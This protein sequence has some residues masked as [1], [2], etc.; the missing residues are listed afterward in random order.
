VKKQNQSGVGHFLR[1]KG[2]V[3]ALMIIAGIALAG[4][5]F[6]EN[7]SAAEMANDGI[8]AIGIVTHKTQSQAKSGSGST[9]HY[10]LSYSLAIPDDPYVRGTQDVGKTLYDSVS[11]GA[12][13]T[14]RYIPTDPSINVADP[15]N[16][17]TNFEFALMAAAGLFL[18]GLIAGALG[19]RRAQQ[20]S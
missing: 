16:R 13:I 8:D 14:V 19:I 18:A 5:K 9:V 4:F 2:W 3:C 10:S 11:E 20:V 15:T 1:D 17:N 6:L 7:Q 12:E